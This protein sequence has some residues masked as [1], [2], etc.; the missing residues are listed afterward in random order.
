MYNN[1]TTIRKMKGSVIMALPMQEFYSEEDYYNIPEDTRAEIIDGQIYYQAAPSRVHQKILSEL[2]ITIGQYIKSKGGSCQIYPAPFSVK[3]FED[4]PTI[5]EPDISIICDNSKLTDRGCTGAPDWIIEIISPGTASHDYIH[6]LN[7]YADAE[8][9]E[10]WIVDP[11]EQTVFV[12]YL[13][14]DKFRAVAHT[15]HDK[16]KV[17]IY[18]DLYINFPDIAGLLYN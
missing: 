10:Y 13:E 8:V 2:H 16:I 7:L 5:V 3:L 6:K 11:L 1:S 12:Y 17:N 14:K 9:R 4:R 15:F 18:N